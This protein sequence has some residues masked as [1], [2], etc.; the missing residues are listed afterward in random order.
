MAEAFARHLG[1]AVVEPSSA[2][3]YPAGIIQPET[4]QVMAERGIR[5]EPR[6]PRSVLLVHLNAIDVL[7]NMSSIPG[8]DLLRDFPGREIQ[9]QVHDPIG[10]SIEI[11]RSVRDQIESK[12]KDLIEELR[13]G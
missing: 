4:I 8:R 2:G 7:V 3:F 13:K 6:P 9:W 10:Q 1:A 11:Y 5:L 12:V